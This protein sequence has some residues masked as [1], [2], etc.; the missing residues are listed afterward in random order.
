MNGVNRHS[1]RTHADARMSILGNAHT[2]VVRDS[3]A[4]TAPTRLSLATQTFEAF[5]HAIT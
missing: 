5:Q 1:G 3:R 4:S 2:I